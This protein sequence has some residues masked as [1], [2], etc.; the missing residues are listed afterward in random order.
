[1]SDFKL[2]HEFTSNGIKI[3][4][5][6]STKTGLSIVLAD[7]EGP[8]VEGAFILATEAHDDDGCPHVSLIRC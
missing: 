2:L 4:K 8:I 3:S 7:I 6:C 1:M 5:Y